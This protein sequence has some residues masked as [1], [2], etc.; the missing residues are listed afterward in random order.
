MGCRSLCSVLTDNTGHGSNGTFLLCFS[1]S[2][3]FSF[4]SVS[5]IFLLK[6]REMAREKTV[7]SKKKKEARNTR[8]KQKKK[9]D[10]HK[11]RLKLIKAVINFK[12]IC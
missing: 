6:E 12:N 11:G 4:F 1:L 7:N 10:K 5:V 9:K 3:Y 8:I 2:L